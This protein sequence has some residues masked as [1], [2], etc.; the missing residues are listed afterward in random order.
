MLNNDE[1]KSLV[2]LRTKLL[3][4]W[5]KFPDDGLDKNALNDWQNLLDKIILKERKR[6]DYTGGQN[7]KL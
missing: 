7:G 3:H 1:L 4:Y 6:I 2:G 5:Q